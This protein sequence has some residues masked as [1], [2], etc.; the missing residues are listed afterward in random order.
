MHQRIVVVMSGGLPALSCLGICQK[1]PSSAGLR[2]GERISCSSR[3]GGASRTSRP[4][5]SAIY[6]GASAASRLIFSSARWGS[7]PKLFT[8]VTV[9]G[10]PRPR[11]RQSCRGP[12]ARAAVRSDPPAAG[13]Y[14][15]GRAGG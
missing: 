1:I 14:H 4:K 8:S 10:A 13:G 9:L 11:P 2:A 3:S 6:A 5:P 7:N 15:P 12:C